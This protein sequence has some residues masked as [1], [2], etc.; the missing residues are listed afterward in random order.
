MTMC[1]LESKM[2]GREIILNDKI[3]SY[4]SFKAVENSFAR[5][6]NNYPFCLN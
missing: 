1:T 2:P 5:K 3:N 4:V 6:T